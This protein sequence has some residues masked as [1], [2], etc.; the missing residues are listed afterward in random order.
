MKLQ[1]KNINSAFEQYEKDSDHKFKPEDKRRAKI[2]LLKCLL[3]VQKSLN[4]VIIKDSF[5]KI[6]IDP[7]MVVN[8]D[9]VMNQYSIILSENEHYDLIDRK[10]FGLKCF[11]KNG[12]I[13]DFELSKYQI[14]S[15]R[16]TKTPGQTPRHERIISQERCVIVS[17]KA[18]QLRQE[19]RE[20]AKQE[21]FAAR[22]LAKQ[23]REDKKIARLNKAEEKKNLKVGKKPNKRN[24]VNN[25]TTIHNEAEDIEK[26]KKKKQKPVLATFNYDN[27][28][29]ENN[30]AGVKW[31]ECCSRECEGSGWYTYEEVGWDNS[32]PAPNLWFCKDCLNALDV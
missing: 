11:E 9:Q 18:A 30:A 22:E 13:T 28:E 16:A 10:P 24:N 1:A 7:N 4:S 31:I 3:A 29:D 23:L 2:G 27:T 6:G 20:I 14:I 26:N 25:I 19:N 12:R 8:V 15:N 21:E 32:K 5:R 17:H